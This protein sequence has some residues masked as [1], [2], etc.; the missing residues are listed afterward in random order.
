VTPPAVAAGVSALLAG[1]V[2]LL[3]FTWA[4]TVHRLTRK[5]VVTS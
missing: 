3:I 4:V 2:L 1:W 5:G